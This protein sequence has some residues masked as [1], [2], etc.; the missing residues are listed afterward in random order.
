MLPLPFPPTPSRLACGAL[1]A[2]LTREAWA[3]ERLSRHAGKTARF[4]SGG[5][6]LSLTIGADGRVEPAGAATAPDVTLTLRGGKLDPFTLFS[7]GMPGFT[8]AAH[9]AGDAALAQ[10]VSDLARDLRWEPQE[11][12]ARI[13]G[14]IPAQRLTA[15]MRA[16]ISGARQAAGRLA[17]NFAEYL[18]EED[19][20][21][22]GQP[23]LR[24]QRQDIAGLQA[25]LDALEQGAARLRA[26]LARLEQG[27]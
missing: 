8:G 22:T 12:L 14:D 11:D 3:R 4:A 1:N 24:R 27:A 20:V 13:V 17:G 23:A 7:K 25:S 26:R 5:Q 19:P 9:I 15:G 21:L 6:S 16:F 18:S 2:L 10:T